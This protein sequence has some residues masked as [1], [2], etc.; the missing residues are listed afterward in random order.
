MLESQLPHLVPKGRARDAEQ[1][2]SLG[3][4][5]TG[6]THGILDVQTFRAFAHFGETCNALARLVKQ[7]LFGKD[8]VGRKSA[9]RPLSGQARAPA[10]CA[11]PGCFPA[12]HGYAMP[13]S[14]RAS[15]DG[16]R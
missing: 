8:G 3:D 6:L 2:R 15:A 13:Q 11:A 16:T 10:D 12:S 4:F 14:R 1:G 7:C 5:A 9:A